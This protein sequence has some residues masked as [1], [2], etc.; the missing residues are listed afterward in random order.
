MLDS[1][2][3]SSYTDDGT[4]LRVDRRNHVFALVALLRRE[5][6]LSLAVFLGRD[7]C[8]DRSAVSSRSRASG[9]YCKSSV[10]S[11][12]EPWGAAGGI[13]EGLL[14]RSCLSLG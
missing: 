14:S 13:W 4:R 6:G 2:R 7:S 11:P 5:T 12:D 9:N 8:G 10:I 3:L 1:R